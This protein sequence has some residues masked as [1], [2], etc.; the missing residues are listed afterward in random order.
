MQ[1]YID[2]IKTALL[3]FPLVAFLISLP[4]ILSQ[5]HK[6]GAISFWRALIIY[7]F[8][9]YLTCAYFLV[10][11]PLP[12]VSEVATMTTPR[13]QLIPF[14]F[15]VDFVEKTSL[16][17][18]NVRTYLSALTESYVF[19][20]LYN[21][22][23]TLP[24]G[25]YLRYF[26]KCNLRQVALGSFCLS[27]F[28]ELT[29]LSGLYF[30]Y[31]RGYRLFDVDDLLLNTVGGMIG[32]V[33][34]KPLMQFLPDSDQVEIKTR[35]KGRI[36]SGLR[37]SLAFG[38][39]LGACIFLA[40]LINF[41]L[42]DMTWAQPIAIAAVIYYFLLPILFHGS[43][44]IEKFLNLRVVDTKGKVNYWRII[45]RRGIFWCI[46]IGIPSSVML[47]W[48]MSSLSGTLQTWLI[49]GVVMTMFIF[50]GATAIKFLFTTEPLIYEKLSQTRLISTI[51][52]SEVAPEQTRE[53]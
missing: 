30:L 16:N 29:Q 52:V 10:I 44:P 41:F 22:L 37:R 45:L 48:G 21:I 51:Q 14:K 20:P 12:E 46:Y 34:A 32:Y 1:S 50:Y 15:I 25:I 6:Y 9:L 39:D 42:P 4:F 38:I 17:I 26:C 11:M 43:T 24:F 53:D 49:F 18:L 33:V 13:T 36:V 19:V 47:G 40:L 27:L 5:Y 35:Q 7:S 3:V 28:F 23:L 31:P 2:V 8:V